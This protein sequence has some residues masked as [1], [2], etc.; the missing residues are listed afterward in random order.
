MCSDISIKNRKEVSS[1]YHDFWMKG[2]RLRIYTLQIEKR[3]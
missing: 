1:K 2:K 3:L